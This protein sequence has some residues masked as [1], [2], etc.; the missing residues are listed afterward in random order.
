VKCDFYARGLMPAED[1]EV[2]RSLPFWWWHRDPPPQEGSAL[3]AHQALVERLLAD[4]WVP[5]G[6]R[7][8]PWYAQRFRRSLDDSD[9]PAAEDVPAFQS[10]SKVP[11]SP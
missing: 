11:A 5:T 1:A 8:R 7:R 3:A 10:S 6:A 4:G 2:G 9:A